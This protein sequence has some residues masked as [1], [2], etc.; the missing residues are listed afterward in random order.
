MNRKKIKLRKEVRIGIFAVATIMAMYWAINFIKGTDLIRGTSTYYALYDQVS[1]LQTSSNIM[2]RGL[3]VGVIR[4]M[5]FDP[6]MSNKILLELKV[7]SKY[8]IPDDS[9]A[10]IFSDGLMG[11]KALEIV[12]GKSATFLQK[13]DTLRSE[14]DKDFLEVAGSEF[15]FLKQKANTLVNDITH[16]LTSVNTLLD[17]NTGH[18]TATLS[19]VASIS[20]ELDGIVKSE[21]ADIKSIVNNLNA[22]SRSLKQN[23]PRIDRIVGNVEG[24]TD[25]LSSSN[26]PQMI[27]NLS[28]SLAQLNASLEKVNS[29]GGTLGKFINDE[30]LY[31][32]LSVATGNLARLLEDIQANPKRYVNFSVFGGGKK[33]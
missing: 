29:G 11:G 21:S 23:A 30:V 28:S 33:N 27:T 5:E 25:S 24:F 15:E 19:H 16:T 10:L 17:K 12:L 22:L 18:I 20:A 2:I 7:K 13:G 9:K 3:K 26:I 8:K 32:S 6:A 31:D 1:G 14:W 4:R